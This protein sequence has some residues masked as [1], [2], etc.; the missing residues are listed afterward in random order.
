MVDCSIGQR[1]EHLEPKHSEMSTSPKTKT[2]RVWDRK[3]MDE[4]EKYS[5][6]IKKKPSINLTQFSNKSMHPYV[7]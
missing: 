7:D 2:G 5:K 1:T 6:Q 4:R 3:Q